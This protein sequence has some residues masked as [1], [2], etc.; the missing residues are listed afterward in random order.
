LTTGC[1]IGI[2]TRS[3]SVVLIPV[4]SLHFTPSRLS[5]SEHIRRERLPRMSEQLEAT[6]ESVE[7]RNQPKAGARPRNPEVEEAWKVYAWAYEE[8]QRL[9]NASTCGSLANFAD[10]EVA[11]TGALKSKSDAKDEALFAYFRVYD[12]DQRRAFNGDT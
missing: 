2:T 9:L 4:V 10:S 6:R 1:T 12:E 11:R 3:G 7:S 5:E 8:W